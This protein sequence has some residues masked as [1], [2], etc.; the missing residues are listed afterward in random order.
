V[1]SADAFSCALAE[2]QEVLD[3]LGR[4]VEELRGAVAHLQT[5]LDQIR[6]PEDPS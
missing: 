4:T 6:R 2:H 1:T 5:V 3:R